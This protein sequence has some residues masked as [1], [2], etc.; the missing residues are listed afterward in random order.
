MYNKVNR[1]V[2]PMEQSSLKEIMKALSMHSQHIQ[3][4][5]RG[6]EKRLETKIDKMDKKI[7]NLEMKLDTR[8]TNQENTI[9]QR[10]DRL[11]GKFTG[12][13]VELN[14]LQESIHYITS[15]SLQYGRKHRKIH[16]HS[17][18]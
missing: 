14:E 16:E 9:D 13:R 11:D 10:F 5:M 1:E 17:S 18:S 12:M 3:E 4:D 7:N 15:K 8:I 6:M 2:I